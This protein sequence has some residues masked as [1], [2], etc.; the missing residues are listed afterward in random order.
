M[1]YHGKETLGFSINR[2]TFGVRGEQGGVCMCSC[3]CV[4]VCVCKRER[5]GERDRHK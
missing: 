2:N 5:G 1:V 4:C 3:V